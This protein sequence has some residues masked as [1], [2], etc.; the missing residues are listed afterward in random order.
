MHAAA[1]PRRPARVAFSLD[2]G[3]APV[4]DPEV[5]RLCTAAA[6]KLEGD[7]CQVERPA[8][9]SRDAERTF[10]TLRG[11]AF[12]ANMGPLLDKHRDALKPDVIAN[13]EFGFGLDQSRTSCR[14]K[15]PTGRSSAGWPG[16]S[17]N[18]MS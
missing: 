18:T 10:Q 9:I 12:V 8:R 2:L 11:V 17:S 13:A 6:R 14:R 1:N 5:A 4:V 3:V 15:S 16:S 7:G